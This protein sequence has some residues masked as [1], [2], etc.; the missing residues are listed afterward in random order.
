MKKIVI[1]LVTLFSLSAVTY[2]AFPIVEN[3][4]SI[5]VATEL[6]IEAGDK[7]AKLSM[8]FAGIAI[9]F[10]LLVFGASGWGALL[11]IFF[12]GVFYLLAFIFGLLGLGSKSKRWQAF[13]GLFSGLLVLLVLAISTGSTGDPDAKD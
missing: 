4:N 5:S 13:I 1:L 12:A 10:N 9:V 3:C 7:A 11:P 8:I 6:P 2:A